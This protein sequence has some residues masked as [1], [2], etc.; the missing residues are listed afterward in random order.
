MLKPHG[1]KEVP[2]QFVKEKLFAIEGIPGQ[3][4]GGMLELLGQGVGEPL[5]QTL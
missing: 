3:G 2:W 5:G 1:S 4:K